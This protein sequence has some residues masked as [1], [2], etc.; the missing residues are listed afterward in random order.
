MDEAVIRDFWNRHPCG[1]QF[2]GGLRDDYEDFFRRY[3]AHR[4][5]TES[6]IPACLDRIDFR[7]KSVLEI[8]LGEGAESEQ[9]IRRGARW[10][11]IDLTPESVARVSTR[12]AL[13]GL[14][15]DR[16][17]VGSARALPFPDRQFD[18][19]FSHGVLH[20]VPEI[21]QAQR[22]IAR[23]LKPGGM[24]VI[25]VY[26]KWSLNYR[27]SIAVLRRLGLLL[28][29]VTGAR[30]GSIYVAHIENARRIGLWR[31]LKLENFIHY[32]TDGP[33]NPYSK[34]Y[35]VA[36]V[37]RDFPAFRVI[38][39]HKEHMHAPPLPVRGLPGASLLGWHLWVHLTPRG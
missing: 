34:V 35:S 9:I 39:A 12:L 15:Y 14:D 13:R 8:G 32:N 17:A 28:L 5:A 10:S 11:G 33:L 23:V 29:Y 25:M 3:D 18:I 16:I 20:H 37:Q 36:S 26:A 2:V 4:Y 30:P 6:H 22:E 1:E 19:V 7:G 21:G 24:L 38:A 31:Y 27:L